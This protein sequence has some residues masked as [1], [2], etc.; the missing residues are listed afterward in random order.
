MNLKHIYLIVF[1][2]T[3]ITFSFKSHQPAT[4]DS[5]MEFNALNDT[6][7][8]L[9]KIDGKRIE[10]TEGID[11]IR[12]GSN[13][14]KNFK[15]EP[16]S[17]LVIF[18][19]YMYKYP[20]GQADITVSIGTLK[21][22]KF[23]VD[24]ENFVRFFKIGS[25]SFSVLAE[26]GVEITYR[27]KKDQLWSTSKGNQDNSNFEITDLRPDTG[28]VKFKANFNCKLYNSEGEIKSLENGLFIGYF[29]NN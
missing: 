1:L 6:S 29:R 20:A 11:I 19:S 7:H 21:F 14:L 25:Y 17:S 16:D 15:K 10:F 28:F 27:D 22:K 26:N 2:L 4:P 9:A 5:G 23:K 24:N 3:F 13:S 12:N 8:F 18:Q